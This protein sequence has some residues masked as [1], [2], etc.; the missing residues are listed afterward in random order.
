[1]SD[2]N[3]TLAVIVLF[4]GLLFYIAWKVGDLHTELRKI[5][6]ELEKFMQVLRS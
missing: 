5:R 3:L 1:M 6:K 4:F 2:L